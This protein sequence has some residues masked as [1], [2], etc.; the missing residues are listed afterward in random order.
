MTKEKAKGFSSWPLSARLFTIFVLLLSL[1]GL[2]F[3]FEASAVESFKLFGH[4]YHFVR[5]QAMWLGLGYLAFMISSFLPLKW[6]EKF[7]FPLY[8]FGLLLLLLPLVP[9]IGLNLNGASRWIRLPFATFQPVEFF[10]FVFINFYASFLSR[11]NSW[12]VFLFYLLFPAVI[13]LLQPDFGSLLVVLAVAFVL[14]FLSGASWK[15]IVLLL[16]MGLCLALVVTLGSDYRRERLL[17][18]VGLAPDK[19]DESY[20]IHQITLALGNGSWLGRGIGNSQ[21]KYAYVP[22]A[23]SDSIFAIIAEELGF[24]G[25]SVLVGFFA[26]FFLLANR[27]FRRQKETSAYRQ[28]FFYG[29][30]AWIACQVLLNLAAV[31]AL[32]P[33]T[34]V[35]LPFFSQGGSALFMLFIACGLMLNMALHP[36]NAER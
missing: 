20:H 32:V 15:S 12:V 35:P 4:Q 13:L 17:T 7:A 33:L 26:S 10:K 18:F 21:Q 25:S 2:F 30:F 28:L 8:I 1:T 36:K 27:M 3:V 22:E 16:G 34:G 14:Y 11:K 19:S 5:Q 9:G 29:L 31:V 24:I 6:L 23:S